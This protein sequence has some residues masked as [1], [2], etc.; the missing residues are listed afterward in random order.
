MVET[1][2]FGENEQQATGF[3]GIVVTAIGFI[4]AVT[5]VAADIGFGVMTKA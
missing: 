4:D 3:G 2:A 1:M 5:D